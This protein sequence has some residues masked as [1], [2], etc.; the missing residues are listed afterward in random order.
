MVLEGLEIIYKS[1]SVELPKKA[2]YTNEMWWTAA[3]KILLPRG[4][5][6]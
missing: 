2:S 4:C 6:P 3:A 1:K 5:S